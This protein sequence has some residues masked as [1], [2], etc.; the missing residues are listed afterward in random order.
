M[1]RCYVLFLYALTPTGLSYQIRGDWA[2]TGTER[3]QVQ[4]G[5]SVF[6][7]IFIRK[8]F[9][10]IEKQGIHNNLSICLF[11]SKRMISV[12]IVRQN[13]SKL[14]PKNCITLRHRVNSWEKLSDPST[15]LPERTSVRIILGPFKGKEERKKRQNFL[16]FDGSRNVLL[17]ICL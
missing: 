9:G 1:L 4:Y 2:R 10:N 8:K 5:S 15:K 13:V 3:L 11:L 17:H 16:T 14:S 6:L 12:V 7:S